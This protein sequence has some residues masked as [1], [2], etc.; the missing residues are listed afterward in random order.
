VSEASKLLGTIEG[1]RQKIAGKSIP[2]EKF[3][4]KKAKAY[5]AGTSKMPFG[6]LELAYFFNYTKMGNFNS[7]IAQFWLDF[8]QKTPFFRRVGTV[9]QNLATGGHLNYFFKRRASYH[10][11]YKFGNGRAFEFIKLLNEN[12]FKGPRK[13]PGLKKTLIV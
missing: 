1:L 13:S 7:K 9:A 8:V 3:V 6:F 12:M 5:V 4:A 2:D 11:V 10:K